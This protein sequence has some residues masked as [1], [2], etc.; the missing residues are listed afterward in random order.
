MKIKKVEFYQEGESKFGTLYYFNVW[1]EGDDKRYSYASKDKNNPKLTQ[2]LEGDFVIT[3][4]TSSAGKVFYTIKPEPKEF[5][6]SP[7]Q[8][9]KKSPADEKSI[10]AQVAQE[11]SISFL[12][13][14]DKNT[15]TLELVNT[16][17]KDIYKWLV[18]K[19]SGM[20]ASNAIRRAIGATIL[21]SVV[22]PSIE[23]VFELADVFYKQTDPKNYEKH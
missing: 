6:G 14:M 18:S 17:T 13:I 20:R 22:E 1:L 10:A 9:F 12:S 2:G 3:E 5:G 4:K 19:D 11:A 16:Y 7:S 8:S 21:L 15:V 23:K